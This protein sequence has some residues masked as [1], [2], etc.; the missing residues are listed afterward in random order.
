[1]NYCIDCKVLLT[2]DNTYTRKRY[3]K[4]GTARLENNTRCHTCRKA[5]DYK[6][7]VD[8]TRYSARADLSH[9]GPCGVEHLF[10]CQLK[11]TAK[12]RREPESVDN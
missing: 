4:D 7:R 10:F 8:P 9:T 2:P 11:P 5:K 12:P 3:R 1:M 6:S